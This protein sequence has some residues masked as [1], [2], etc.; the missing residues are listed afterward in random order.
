MIDSIPEIN[1][2]FKLRCDSFLDKAANDPM[3][4]FGKVTKGNLVIVISDRIEGNSPVLY[5]LN[6]KGSILDSLVVFSNPCT[7]VNE[8]AQYEPWLE[9]T[10]NLQVIITD[11]TYTT[12]SSIDTT[13]MVNGYPTYR[14][15][16][17]P[18]QN[19]VKYHIGN[20]GDISVVK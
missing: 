14:V 10:K 12:D 19:Q 9:I 6:R 1:L 13:K 11:S 8:T 17:V 15:F 7:Y 3:P 18:V 20:D 4:Y 5:T 16:H 2:P